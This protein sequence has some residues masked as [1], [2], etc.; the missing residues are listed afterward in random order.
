MLA[1]RDRRLSHQ[2]PIDRLALVQMVARHARKV[3]QSS[4]LEQKNS[5]ILLVDDSQAACSLLA[6]WLESR[7]HAVRAVYDG[8]SALHLAQEFHPD[9]VLLDIRL[10]DMNGYQLMQRL[11]DLDGLGPA[12]FIALSGYGEDDAPGRGSVEFDYFIQK[13]LNIEQL[14]SLLYSISISAAAS[15]CAGEAISSEVRELLP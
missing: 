6:N 8:K 10:P 7:G 2:I 14:D 12:I 13:P 4:G 11:R 1:G 9:V 5:K 15:P 3:A